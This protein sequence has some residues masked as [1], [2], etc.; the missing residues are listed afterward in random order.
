[1]KCEHCEWADIVARYTSDKQ[2]YIQIF[3]P[4]V[5][6]KKCDEVEKDADRK[7]AD[8]PAGTSGL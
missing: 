1:M 7:E 2:E 4:F 5:G 6:C 8:K 3:C